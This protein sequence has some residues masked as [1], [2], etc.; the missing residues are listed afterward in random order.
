MYN[1]DKVERLVPGIWDS[2]AVLTARA[3]EAPD[4]DMPKGQI[5]PRRASDGMAETAD[6]QRAWKM[7]PLSRRQ[8]QC[9]LLRYGLGYTPK[10]IEPTLG[11]SQR[12]ASEHSIAGI[13]RLTRFLNYGYAA[14]FPDLVDL[15]EI[16][17][18][19]ESD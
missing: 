16:E 15:D 9:V 8:R 7:A 14:W 19:A 10:E 11:I 6:I 2:Q 12:D 5:D 13:D 17:A 3:P 18:H 4:P 1:A